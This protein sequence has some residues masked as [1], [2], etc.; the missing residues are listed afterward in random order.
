MKMQVKLSDREIATL[1]ASLRNWQTDGLNEDLAD[2]F[3]GHFEEHQ[4]LSDDEIDEL[5]EKLNFA[6]EGQVV[7]TGA[8]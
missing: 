7:T 5:C 2:A 6:G 3:C 8:P 4:P 1:L